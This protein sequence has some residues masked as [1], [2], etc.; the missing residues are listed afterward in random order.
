MSRTKDIYYLVLL[1]SECAGGCV[2]DEDP[3]RPPA[4]SKIRILNK[5]KFKQDLTNFTK[6]CIETKKGNPK[7]SL[8]LD[9]NEC[10]EGKA[11]KKG[12]NGEYQF[13]DKCPGPLGVRSGQIDPS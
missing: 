13:D 12:V 3:W 7:K 10:W 5:S 1:P 4:G 9:H 8:T 2:P 11:G 6:D